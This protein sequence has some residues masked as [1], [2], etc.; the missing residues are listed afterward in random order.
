MR[1]LCLRKCL[2]KKSVIVQIPR[3][4]GA[5]LPMRDE[6]EEEYLRERKKRERE[7]TSDGGIAFLC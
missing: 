5:L 6:E 4:Y 1:M 2:K 7:Q 3:H